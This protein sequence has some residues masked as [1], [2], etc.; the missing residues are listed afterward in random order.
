[1]IKTQRVEKDLFWDAKLLGHNILK[2]LPETF[3]KSCQGKTMGRTIIA[4]L[5]ILMLDFLTLW[6]FCTFTTA[7]VM[8]HQT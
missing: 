7:R 1:M 3:F 6:L 8:K 2:M 5:R 4:L